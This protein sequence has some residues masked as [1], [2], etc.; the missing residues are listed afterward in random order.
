M[1]SV[2]TINASVEVM[3][4]ALNLDLI[5]ELMEIAN[6]VNLMRIVKKILQASPSVFPTL[7]KVVVL[8]I[9]ELVPLLE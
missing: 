5:V 6:S 3:R 7:V 1:K 4:P 8:E 2:Q 9:Y